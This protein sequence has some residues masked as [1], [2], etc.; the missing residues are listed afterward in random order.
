MSGGAQTQ[1]RVIASAQDLEALVGGEALASG[2]VAIDQARVNAFADATVDHQWI[3][4]D[5]ARAK[6]ESPFGGPIAHGFLTLS[7]IPALMADAMRFEQR[8]GV[9]YGL[10]RVR[11]LKPV[12]VDARLRACFVLKEAGEGAQGGL[13]ATWTV[14]VEIEHPDAPMPACAAEFVTLHY[15]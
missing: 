9:N 11:F 13:L 12:P 4:V 5:P 2:W 6:R 14:S 10:N 1:A 7:L 3:H 8:M 15:F